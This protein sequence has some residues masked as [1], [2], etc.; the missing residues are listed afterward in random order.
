MN[1]KGLFEVMLSVSHCV[2]EEYVISVTTLVFKMQTK[3][4]AA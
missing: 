2:F 4:A 1:K 3:T